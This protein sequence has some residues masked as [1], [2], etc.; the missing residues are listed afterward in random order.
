MVQPVGVFALAD[1][2]GFTGWGF[3]LGW[4]D[5]TGALCQRACLALSGA[6][7]TETPA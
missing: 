2:S 6:V 4:V 5:L 7:P 1:V 3:A